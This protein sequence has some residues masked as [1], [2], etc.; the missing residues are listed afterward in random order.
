M[1]LKMTILIE[2]YLFP[3]VG[4]PSDMRVSII[5]VDKTRAFHIK[6]TRS[7]EQLAEVAPL[8]ERTVQQRDYSYRVEFL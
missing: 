8:S 5:A 1:P 4:L 3:C 7:Q 6:Q 2:N